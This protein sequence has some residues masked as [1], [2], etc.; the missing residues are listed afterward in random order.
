M[1]GDQGIGGQDYAQILASQQAYLTGGD[2]S[3]ARVLERAYGPK[4]I[5][6][7]ERMPDAGVEVLVYVVRHNA[8]F[9]DVASREAR[10]GGSFLWIIPDN[11]FELDEV[12]HWMPLP[13][14]PNA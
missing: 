7:A 10:P 13:E 14:P 9:I 8:R 12:T 6:C 2:A 1:S 4:W 3:N 5:R 11:D